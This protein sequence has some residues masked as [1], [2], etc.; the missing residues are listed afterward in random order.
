MSK[1]SVHSEKLSDLLRFLKV[2]CEHV[3]NMDQPHLT[4]TRAM[5]SKTFTDLSVYTENIQT[6]DIEIHQNE[7]F[8]PLSIVQIDG[9]IWQLYF[10][11]LLL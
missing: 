11:L 10:A 1:P 3:E 8:S 4:D 5:L 6:T 2:K 9:E 7:N